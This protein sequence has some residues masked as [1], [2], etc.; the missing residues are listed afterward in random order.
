MEEKQDTW[1]VSKKNI[2]NNHVGDAKF[3]SKFIL[4]ATFH[5]HNLWL[6][7]SGTKEKCGLT[8]I[9]NSSARYF[10]MA[11]CLDNKFVLST[12]FRPSL[13]SNSFLTGEATESK[14]TRRIPFS[15]RSSSTVSNLYG[16]F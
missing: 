16:D 1:T 15:I 2:N 9:E 4:S 5:L 11:A 10:K 12:M 6:Q 13:P 8:G 3:L 7:V 14:I